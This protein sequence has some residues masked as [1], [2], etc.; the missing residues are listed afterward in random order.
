MIFSGTTQIMTHEDRLAWQ[1]F[2]LQN[3][4]ENCSVSRHFIW[5]TSVGYKKITRCRGQRSLHVHANT[6]FVEKFN[7]CTLKYIKYFKILSIYTYP[8]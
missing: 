7:D 6:P 8:D 4:V 2:I 5:K 1:Q 3:E